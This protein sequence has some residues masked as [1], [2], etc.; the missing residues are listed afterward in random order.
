V[1]FEPRFGGAR[2]FLWPGYTGGMRVLRFSAVLASLL[3]VSCSS[4]SDPAASSGTD[5]GGT[6]EDTGA[7]GEDTT[8]PGEDTAPGEV[9]YP[10]GPY[11][12]ELKNTFPDITWD[13]YKNA[14]GDWTK[15]SMHDY[16]DPDGSKGINAIY[17]VVSAQWCVPCQGEAKQLTR[18][19]DLYKPT[20]S[21]F[22]SAMLQASSG[23]PSTQKVVDQWI[24]AYK[25]DFDIVNAPTPV[26]GSDGMS[27]SNIVP[28]SWAIPRNYVIDPRTM[29]V[30]RVI[31]S[32]LATDAPNI[33]V[34]SLLLR[35]NGV[36][37]VP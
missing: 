7:P 22:I 12:I 18:L 34:L 6:A 28:K 24:T 17:L 37:T 23:A 16:Y 30:Y 14:T 10:E 8:P 19:N 13:G 25:I 2:G 21:N 4:K 36:E 11:G 15:I 35:Q 29:K 9:T 3:A 1:R 27:Q 26:A 33:P 5:T 20:G 31:M 32:A